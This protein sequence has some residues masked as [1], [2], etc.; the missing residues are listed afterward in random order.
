M[1]NSY[2][3]ER[4]SISPLSF[5]ET[6]FILALVNTPGWIKFIGDR[7]VNNLKEA[8]AYIKKIKKISTIKYWVVKLKEDEIPIGIVT[9]IKRDYLEYHDI[10]FAFLPVYGKKGYALE[11]ASVVLNQVSKQYKLRRVLATTVKDNASSI[12][13]LN[14]LGFRF[15]EEI[16]VD[17]RSLLVY[18]LPMENQVAT[19]QC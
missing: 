13:L 9:L 19:K 12:N 17:D 3:T 5:N 18:N 1:Q 15:G 10:G 16:Q 8:K 7:K 4:L 2:T 11:A 14:K 6:E